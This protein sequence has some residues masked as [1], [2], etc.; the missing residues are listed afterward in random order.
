MKINDVVKMRILLEH[1]EVEKWF[2]EAIDKIEAQNAIDN[3]VCK[4]MRDRAPEWQGGTL[5]EKRRN[6]QAILKEVRAK[7]EGGDE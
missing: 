4:D 1:F 6:Y 7:Y 5:G 3:Q 2:Q